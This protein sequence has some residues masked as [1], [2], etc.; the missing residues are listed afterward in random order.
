MDNLILVEVFKTFKKLPEQA[1][2]CTQDQLETEEK[3]R[4]EIPMIVP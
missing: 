4:A 3:I 2:D 1:F